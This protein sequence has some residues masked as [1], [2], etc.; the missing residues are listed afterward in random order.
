MKQITTK[1][2]LEIMIDNK[3]TTI[4][5]SKD[6]FNKI[7]DDRI[8]RQIDIKRSELHEDSLHEFKSYRNGYERVCNSINEYIDSLDDY[9]IYSY[10]NEHATMLFLTSN[11][12]NTVIINTFFK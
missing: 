6:G 10:E 5:M 8:S 12:S 2:A 1:Q 9:T 3:G 7:T 4:Y 11:T